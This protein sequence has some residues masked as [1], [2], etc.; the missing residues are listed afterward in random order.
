MATWNNILP[1][2]Q[3]R[4]WTEKD[5]EP[6]REN[7][8]LQEALAAGKWA[9]VSDVVRLYALYAEGGV[10]LD[11]DVEVRRRFDDFLDHDF[12]IGAER[13]GNFKSVGTAVIG[14]AK[15]NPLVKAMLAE[16]DKAKFVLDNGAFD[17]TPNTIRLVDVLLRAGAPKVYTEDE[18]IS[19]NANSK[20]YP[21]S[22]FCQSSPQGYCVHHF[23]FS[24]KPEQKR[25]NKWHFHWRGHRYVIAKV[26]LRTPAASVPIYNN[27]TEIFR[28]RYFPLRMLV[29]IREN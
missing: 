4:E 23:N 11:T 1:D 16:Y 7:I 2:Y 21:V 29:L 5:L 20:I 13:H 10:Y 18:I 17:Y 28:L 27:E 15:G 8:Y 19:L 26:T 6:L 3:V 14:A 12:F 9:F 22:Y 25:K 24:W